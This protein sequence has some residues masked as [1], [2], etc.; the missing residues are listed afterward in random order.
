MSGELVSCETS[1]AQRVAGGC[2]KD[3][4]GDRYCLIRAVE[5]DRAYAPIRYGLEAVPYCR[6]HSTVGTWY[7]RTVG[8]VGTVGRYLRYLARV[9]RSVM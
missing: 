8:T 6:Y 9:G 2:Q 3:S 4:Y 1:P 5:S 7:L